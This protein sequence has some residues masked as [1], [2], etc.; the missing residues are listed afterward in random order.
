MVRTIKKQKEQSSLLKKILKFNDYKDCLLSNEIILKSQQRLK[1][2]LIMY[3]LKKSVKLHEVAMM[4]K[5]YRLLIELHHIPME[6]VLEKFAK[7]KYI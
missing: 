2:K 1:V 7:Q 3:I 4:I 5:D 6:Q